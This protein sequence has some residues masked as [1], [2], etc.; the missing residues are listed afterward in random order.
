MDQKRLD[1]LRELWATYSSGLIDLVT[2]ADGG[3]IEALTELFE[4]PLDVS[5]R[6]PWGPYHYEGG[7]VEFCILL[8]TGGPAVRI[9]GKWGDNGPYDSR[10]EV[11]D[12]ATDWYYENN[13]RIRAA[14]MSFTDRI[15]CAG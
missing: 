9:I 6:G 10:L 7:P 4:R 14:I 12:W 3:D 8:T 15:L 2:A 5:W 1:H 13:E 11:R